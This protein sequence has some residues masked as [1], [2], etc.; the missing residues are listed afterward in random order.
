VKRVERGGVMSIRENILEKEGRKFPG[1]TYSEVVLAPAYEHAKHVLLD[2]MIAIHKGHLIMLVEQGL[3]LEDEAGHIMD[4]IRA[5]DMCA[6]RESTYDGEYEDLFFLVESKIMEVAGEVGGSLHLARS[7]NDM[8]VAMYRMVLRSKLQVALKSLLSFQETLLTVIDTYKETICLGHTHTQQAQPMTFSHYLLGVYDVVD[9]DI[10][11][12]KAAYDTCN[13]SPLGAAAL[14]TTGFPIDRARVADLLGF[15]KLVKSAYDSISGADYLGEIATSIQ[16]AFINLGRF[17]Q[18]L[19]LWC[20]QEFSAVRVADP[21][22]Q[23]S[24]IM[25]QKRNPVSLEHIRALSS[26]GIGNAQTVLQMLHNTPYGDINDTEDDLQPYLWKGLSLIDQV[27]RLTKAVVGTIEVNEEVL[28]KRAKESLATIT[29]LADTLFREAHIP[30]RTAHSIT[31]CVVKFALARGVNAMQ[32]TSA[33]V[34]EAAE[35]VIGKPLELPEAVIR[36]AMD[37]E[38]FIKVRSLPGGTAPEEMKRG[39][40]ERKEQ[41]KENMILLETEINRIATCMERLDLL[42]ENWSH[43]HEDYSNTSH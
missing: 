2:P 32:I 31:S 23:T 16:L 22:V 18:D 14:T 12:L 27:F 25:P 21:Y 13:A 4:G 34:D 33:L 17:S 30:F 37:P 26:S 20:T 7:R 19:L 15:P 5:L 43:N 11:R 24:S 42:T 38:H 29:E 41:L 35:S 1:T 28:K 6:L 9:R 10:K 3:L 40:K 8:G 36:A 39:I